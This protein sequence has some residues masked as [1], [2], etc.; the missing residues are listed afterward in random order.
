MLFS[1]WTLPELCIYVLSPFFHSYTMSQSSYISRR[2]QREASSEAD[3]DVRHLLNHLE[4]EKVNTIKH[5]KINSLL[6]IFFDILKQLLRTFKKIKDK[7]FRNVYFLIF[8]HCGVYFI[9]TLFSCF[10]FNAPLCF[11]L[12]CF[13]INTIQIFC[14]KISSRLSFNEIKSYFIQN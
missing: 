4:P 7:C 10:L 3:T 6:V 14:K 12:L 2:K 11:V 1:D 8:I 5:H 9:V 13:L